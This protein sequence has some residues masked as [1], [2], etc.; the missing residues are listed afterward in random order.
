M[1][2]AKLQLLVDVVKMDLHRAHA[3]CETRGDFL[4]VQTNRNQPE[5]LELARREDAFELF[6]DGLTLRQPVCE[7][8]AV[9]AE[10]LASGIHRAQAVLEH[11]RRHRLQ[12]DPARAQPRRRQQIV[13]ILTGGEHNDGG[14]FRRVEPAKHA[15]TV[16][17]SEL[18]VEHQH[19]GLQR[20]D[21]L[22][23][24][25]RGAARRE[26]LEVRTRL[27]QLLQT[28]DDERVIVD[29]YRFE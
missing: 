29:E 2:A 11:A 7:V 9:D 23:S 4:I 25:R 1:A 8:D 27:E 6:L 18:E 10:T 21:G 22:E 28:L 16:V 15:Q 5:D 20:L 14:W 3:D 12:H 24:F 17:S 13:F 19:V 26:H